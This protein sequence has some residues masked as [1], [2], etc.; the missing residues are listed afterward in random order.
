M[1]MY[2]YAFNFCT[3]QAIQKYLSS[4][5]FTHLWHVSETITKSFA[6]FFQGTLI[7][8]WGRS[9]ARLAGHR[10][11]ALQQVQGQG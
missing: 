10:E 3:S 7:L 4:E 8:V 1:R 2:F 11:R 5:I 6:Y 9:Q